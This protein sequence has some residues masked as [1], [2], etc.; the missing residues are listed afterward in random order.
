M[1]T[2][3]R[4]RRIVNQ[5]G[6]TFVTAVNC[7]SGVPSI[8]KVDAPTNVATHTC[9]YIPQAEQRAWIPYSTLPLTTLP[10]LFKIAPI[11]R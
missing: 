6:D 11:A 8:N 3:Y 9:G 1:S 5:I 7:H 10:F 4:N 2:I